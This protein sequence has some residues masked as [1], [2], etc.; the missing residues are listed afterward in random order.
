MRA[1]ASGTGGQVVLRAVSRFALMMTGQW[2][3]GRR[4]VS[5]GALLLA[6]LACSGSV[7][8]ARTVAL[9]STLDVTDPAFTTGGTL[10][11]GFAAAV[12]AATAKLFVRVVAY[13]I[14][15]DGDLDI[16]ANDGTLELL[17][18]ENDGTG[19]FARKPSGHLA[20]LEAPPPET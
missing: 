14:D 18:W 3:R 5:A 13:D 9:E 17:V 11:P 15:N 10:P 12:D 19:H 7:G 4:L 6:S 2:A 8:A 20:G 1:G 16:V